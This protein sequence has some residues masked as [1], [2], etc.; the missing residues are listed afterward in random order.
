MSD[1]VTDLA[2]LLGKAN[3]T[4]DFCTSGTAELLAPSL[5][6]E[7]VGPISLPLLPVQAAQL[8]A[9][10]EQAPYG[11]GPDTVIDT[12][13]RNSWQIGPDRVKIAGRHWPKTLESILERAAEGLG[14][15]DPIEAEFY[16]LLIYPRGSFFV[17]GP[18]GAGRSR[19]RRAWRALCRPAATL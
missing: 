18:S 16:K 10:A 9:A 3:R 8:V 4:G 12:T 13:V 14:V 1:T 6:V 15:T 17:P 19:R 7:G 5:T 11:K 2:A